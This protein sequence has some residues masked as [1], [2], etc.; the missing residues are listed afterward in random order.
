MRA[1]VASYCVLLVLTGVVPA[2]RDQSKPAGHLSASKAK[3]LQKRALVCFTQG[4]YAC[5]M[6][7]LAKVVKSRPPDAELLNQFAM[8]ARMRYYQSGD[9]DYRDQELDGL[10]K[11]VGLAPSVA[12]I[13][14]NF[15][16]T[17][18]ALGMRKVAAKAYQRGLELAPKHPDAALMRARIKRSTVEVEDEEEQ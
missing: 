5:A 9:M 8:A 6:E 15:G 7:G 17:A 2:C 12:H 10:R 16:T 18:W 11:A 14:I 13:Q 1:R 4:D 3:D